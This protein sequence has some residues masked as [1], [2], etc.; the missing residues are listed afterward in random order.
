[1]NYIVRKNDKIARHTKNSVTRILRTPLTKTFT[2]VERAVYQVGGHYNS[3]NV[4][5]RGFIDSNTERHVLD[6]A[7]NCMKALHNIDGKRPA[8]QIWRAVNTDT[9]PM[10]VW[11]NGQYATSA[12]SL[13]AAI[14]S[15]E[16]YYQMGAYKFKIPNVPSNLGLAVSIIYETGGALVGQG[17]AAGKLATQYPLREAHYSGFDKNWDDGYPYPVNFALYFGDLPSRFS[18]F[19]Y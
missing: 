4:P 3:N 6:V 11:Y 16:A 18:T 19:H 9:Q 10:T 7:D 2:A 5:D 14:A 17:P 1:M 12:T 8:L 15:C 13:D